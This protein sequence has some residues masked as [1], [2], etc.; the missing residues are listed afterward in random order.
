ML[1]NVAYILL[2]PIPKL[3]DFVLIGLHNRARSSL[4]L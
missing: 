2:F 4:L 1:N 3:S